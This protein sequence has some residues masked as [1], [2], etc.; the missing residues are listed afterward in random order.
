MEGA[1][2]GVLAAAALLPLLGAARSL[3]MHRHPPD[4]ALVC[5]G[6]VERELAA[7]RAG[8][9]CRPRVR[10]TVVSSGACDLAR[11]DGARAPGDAPVL[12]DRRAMCTVSN[13]TS[14][15]RDF[16]RARVRHVLVLTSAEHAP[17]AFSAAQ[18]VFRAYGIA[19]SCQRVPVQHD[20]SGEGREAMWRVV[21]D[22]VRALLFAL[23]GADMGVAKLTRW[24]HPERER[25]SR[26]WNAHRPSLHLPARRAA[27]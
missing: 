16:R 3:S 19:V 25:A 11:L 27:S 22:A 20:R 2:V 7:V 9:S 12:E 13:M 26:E 14:L 23:V 5:G 1:L 15:L 10:A 6:C 4:V 18:I 17:R 21:R 8:G 24:I